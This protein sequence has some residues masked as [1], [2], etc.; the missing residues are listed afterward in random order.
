MED[1]AFAESI[2]NTITP[3]IPTFANK[4]EEAI[5]ELIASALDKEFDTYIFYNSGDD[6]GLR[7]T[8]IEFKNGSIDIYRYNITEN[9]A[10]VTIPF[11][12]TSKPEQA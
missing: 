8:L 5:K 6:L 3:L 1:T 11:N 12:Q 2:L 10:K 7:S 9:E 4:S